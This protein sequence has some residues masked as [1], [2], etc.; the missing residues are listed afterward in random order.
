MK[1]GQE[2]C[3]CLLCKKSKRYIK[4]TGMQ[5][6]LLVDD[7]EDNLLSIETILSSDGYDFYKARS[8]KEAL[9]ILLKETDFAMI[10]MD[11][12]MPNLNGFETATLIYAREK[13]RNIPI[14]F[15]TA[16]NYGEDSVFKGYKA[17]AVDY[18]Y[19]PMNP[20][21]LRAK[22]GVFIEI[23]KKNHRLRLHEQK[24]VATNLHLAKEIEERVKSEEQVKELNEQL[25]EKIR[26]LKASNEE[27]DNFAYIAS[28]D[29]Q[30]PLRKIR[31]FSDVLNSK[32]RNELSPQAA[33]YLDKI[34]R[35]SKRMQLLIDDILSFSRFS[36]NK[37]VFVRTDLNKVLESVLIDLEVATKEKN[38]LVEVG[39][40]PKVATIPVL[41]HQLFQN[42]ISN[43]IKFSHP[44]VPPVVKVTCEKV[45]GAALPGIVSG[46]EQ[47]EFFQIS[48]SD[49][50]IGFEKQYSEM[51][52]D[53][54][55]RLHANSQFE[56]SGIGLAICRKIATRHGGYIF[57][58]SMPGK[59]SVFS[60]AL[61]CEIYQPSAN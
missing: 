50:G 54:F 24:L 31:T 1:G 35:S 40:L 45:K 14:I 16:N 36:S 34:D 55:K 30:E 28:H 3:N 17:G 39:K 37:D 47:S 52:F 26:Q 22:V 58:D 42:L 41:M 38:A 15:I 6:I 49:N 56:G 53:I 8:G 23:Y 29:L 48:I 7:R 12:K 59:G 19:K 46:K 20:D 21:L 57:A 43:A 2:I 5:K 10:L 60:V 13:L 9:K 44:Q 4:L 25:M 61:P 33:E 11:V 18:I 27:L 51:I 32:F